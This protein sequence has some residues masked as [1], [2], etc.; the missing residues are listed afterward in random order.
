M[1][2][3]N[4]ALTMVEFLDYNCGYCMRSYPEVE[5]LLAD[6]K[7]L[8]LVIKEFPV[9]GPGSEFAAKAALASRRQGKYDQFFHAL[10]QHKGAKNEAVVMAAASAT[11]LDLDKLR[12]DMADPAIAAIIARNYQLAEALAINGT[13]AFVIADKIEHGAVGRE[14]LGARIAAVREAGGCNIC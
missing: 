9:L 3:P 7:D 2:N 10:M 8:R 11:G 14:A 12:Q 1:G 4:G 6:N 13:P 5:Q